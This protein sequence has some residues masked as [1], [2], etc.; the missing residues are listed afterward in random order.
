MTFSWNVHHLFL[1]GYI[2]CFIFLNIIASLIASF[3]RKKFDQKSMRLGF[4]TTILLLFLFIPSLFI[5]T[6][7]QDLWAVI[8]ALLL[9]GGSSA[10]VWN[11]IVLFLTM[12]RVRK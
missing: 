8:Q 5:V 11:S 6:P 9:I 12:K 3:Y 1:A 7:R 2:L 10:S 4:G